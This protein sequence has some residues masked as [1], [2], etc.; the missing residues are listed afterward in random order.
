MSNP[1]PI[2]VSAGTPDGG[3]FAPSSR[4]ESPVDLPDV[5][6]PIEPVT[7]EPAAVEA[8]P[9]RTAPGVGCTNMVDYEEEDPVI[10]C[11][12]EG[13]ICEDCTEAEYAERRAEYERDSRMP[14]APNR[15]DWNDAYSDNPAKR[16]AYGSFFG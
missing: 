7:V 9:S 14:Q 12:D 10:T 16:A 4:S 6:E 11:G 15:D 2:R 8:V 13:L 3:R 1:N 5:D